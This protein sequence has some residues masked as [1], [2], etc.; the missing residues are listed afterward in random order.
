VSS[1]GKQIL[2]ELG[3]AL[4]PMEEGAPSKERIEADPAKARRNARVEG[5]E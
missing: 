3:Q 1:A 2:A 4:E 5:G